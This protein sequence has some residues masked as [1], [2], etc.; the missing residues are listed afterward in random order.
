MMTE[1]IHKCDNCGKIIPTRIENDIFGNPREIIEYGEIHPFCN[2]IVAKDLEVC[3]D[4]ADSINTSLIKAKYSTLLEKKESLKRTAR[5]DL[6]QEITDK[7]VKACN[8]MNEVAFYPEKFAL[9]D[10]QY[11]NSQEVVKVLS[12]ILSNHGGTVVVTYG[13]CR[14]RPKDLNFLPRYERVSQLL[15]SFNTF[16]RDVTFIK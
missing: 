1:I 2:D 5:K 7:L 3:Q 11:Y 16:K 12:D 9:N 8:D 13:S 14:P 15:V 4:C 6:I 10:K